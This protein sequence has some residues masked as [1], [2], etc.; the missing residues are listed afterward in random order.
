MA[1]LYVENIPDDLYA[2]L[3]EYARHNRKSIAAVVTALLEQAVV[4]PAELKAREKFLRRAKALRSKRALNSGPF[5]S[6]E[7]M[8][9]EDRLR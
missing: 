9:R 4:T 8:Q 5:P 2:A 7:Q 3:R 1:T 6:T